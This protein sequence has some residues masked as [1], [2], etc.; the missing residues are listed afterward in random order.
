MKNPGTLILWQYLFTRV[1]IINSTAHHSQGGKGKIADISLQLIFRFVAAK[2]FFHLQNA[3]THTEEIPIQILLPV[4][5]LELYI[6]TIYI[7]NFQYSTCT[8]YSSCGYQYMHRYC[9][10]YLCWNYIYSYI[11]Y[12]SYTFNTVHC[13]LYSSCGYQYRYC[14]QY[15]FWNYV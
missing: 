14:L 9:F 4:P 15:I 7:L 12:T 8:L 6:Y 3:H 5:L 1:F 10:Q 13:T 2:V 11:P